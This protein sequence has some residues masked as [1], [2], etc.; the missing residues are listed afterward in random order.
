MGIVGIYIFLKMIPYPVMSYIEIQFK[1]WFLDEN[2]ESSIIIPYHTK[3]YSGG[4][5]SKPIEKTIYS[6]RFRAMNY[7]IMKN[8]LNKLFSLTE[9]INFENSKYL[10]DQGNYILLPRNNQKIKICKE[11]N[12]FFEVVFERKNVDE[13][14]KKEDSVESLNSVKKYIYKISKKGKDNIH[15]LHSFLEEVLKEYTNEVLNKSIQMV[16]EYQKILKDED[17]RI[18]TLFKEIPFK[19]NKNFGNLFFEGKSEFV[20]YI[21]QFSLKVE[22]EKKDRIQKKY[23]RAG[24]P[25]KSVILLHGD[26]GCGK[27][28]LIKATIEYTGRHCILVSWTKIRTCNDFVSLFRPLKINEKT[29]YSN[30]LI[31]VFEDFDANDSDIIKK[32]KN[33]K[34]KVEKEEENAEENAEE[35]E[36]E[37][38]EENAEEG[39]CDNKE[40]KPI[41]SVNDNIIKNKILSEIKNMSIPNHKLEDVITLEFILNVL[42]GIIELYDIIVFFTTNDIDIIDPALKRTGRVDRMIKMEKANRT[43]IK[44]MIAYNYDI[45]ESTMAQYENEINRIPEYK[46]SY[47]DISQI[48]NNTTNVDEC[49]SKIIALHSEN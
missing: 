23:Q 38:E 42:D 21:S 18:V 49:L 37:N 16:F 22:D 5:T 1:E 15:Y 25:Y 9:I 40:T 43:N 29:Y 6:E 36:E 7:Y 44:E 24:I 19:T 12:I 3:M 20:D 32:R 48:C 14:A 13:N 4:F 41:M 17:D 45:S 46:N 11:E 33:M 30:E 8:H 47:S 34:T 28:S 31:L 39:E 27:S 35:N 10:E 26:P 2:N